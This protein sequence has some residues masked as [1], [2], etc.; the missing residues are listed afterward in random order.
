MI[1]GTDFLKRFIV[2]IDYEGKVVAF[3]KKSATPRR[4]IATI[5]FR[6]ENNLPLV[7]VKISNS[8]ET[9]L[10]IDTGHFLEVLLYDDISE[11]LQLEEPISTRRIG[12]AAEAHPMKVGQIPWIEIGTYRIHSVSVGLHP[13]TVPNT[14]STTYK[15]GLLG[16]GI[17]E[18]YV[19]EIDYPASVMRL[20]DRG[21]VLQ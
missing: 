13:L 4:L 15:P 9:Q 21:K 6:L 10:I 2:H 16:N 8:V 11:R 5:P 14:F 1:L 12:G 18:N 7:E 20:Y 3:M 19:V 17:L